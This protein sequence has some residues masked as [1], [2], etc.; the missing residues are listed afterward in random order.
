MSARLFHFPLVTIPTLMALL[1]TGSAVAQTT[2]RWTDKSGRVHYTDQPPRPA[3][4]RDMEMKKL[5]GPN[6]I[7]TGGAFSY[8][9]AQ[10]TK[11]A[12]LTLYISDK[13][14]ENCKK[15]RDL[16]NWR[17]APYTEKVIRTESDGNEFRAATGS[18]DL[19]VPVLKA[20][21][22]SAKG[23]EETAW[24]RLLDESGYPARGNAKAASD[25]GRNDKDKDGGKDSKP[26]L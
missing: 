24:N 16:L 7:D 10:A 12:P 3:D 14:E 6:V 1:L 21:E 15:A 8:E 26:A 19:F 22:K 4:V 17:G 11:N 20:G 5:N 9:T 2:Y 18:R 23:F 13:C 25:R